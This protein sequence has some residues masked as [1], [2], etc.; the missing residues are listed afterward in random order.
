MH[1]SNRNSS[2][3]RDEVALYPTQK[4]CPLLT[5]GH[6]AI[7]IFIFWSCHQWPTSSCPFPCHTE[8]FQYL[9]PPSCRA[10]TEE[11]LGKQ[12]S[13]HML[14]Q[15]TR[16]WVVSASAAQGTRALW[17]CGTATEWAGLAGELGA[18]QSA[19]LA[20]CTCRPG[21]VLWSETSPTKHPPGYSLLSPCPTA[22]PQGHR[23]TTTG[24]NNPPPPQ[25]S[26]VWGNGESRTTLTQTH[27][28]QP[29]VQPAAATKWARISEFHCTA[30]GWC[31][32]AA[33]G[34]SFPR[35]D[36]AALPS[37]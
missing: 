3:V 9:C 1:G 36:G 26:E 31:R 27:S 20:T 15:G 37:Q 19:I 34:A 25:P 13:H 17:H 14:P 8:T 18:H 21:C 11:A 28:A 16:G 24:T 7:N 10:R 32:W 12:R 30:A 5:S 35:R 6:T 4:S 33:A 22:P 29:R 23:Q 2:C